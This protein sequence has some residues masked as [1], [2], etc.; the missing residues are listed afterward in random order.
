MP[1]QRSPLASHQ[2]RVPA[3]TGVRAL[4]MQ[5]AAENPRRGIGAFT[6][7]SPG[8]ATR[9]A[10]PPSGRSSPQQAS[11][12]RRSGRS[13]LGPVPLPSPSVACRMVPIMDLG[14]RVGRLDGRERLKDLVG[15]HCPPRNNPAIT[16]LQQDHLPL[17]VQLGFPRDHITHGLV[18]PCRLRLPLAWRSVPPQPHPDAD[19]GRQVRLSHRAAR[20][21]CAVN[22]GDRLVTHEAIQLVIPP[23]HKQP[24]NDRAGPCPLP[25]RSGVRS[26]LSIGRGLLRSSTATT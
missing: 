26:H 7:G 24:E 13:D 1:N 14:R 8:S 17:A 18:I 9:S 12:N 23:A 5:L 10:P 22:L 2:T 6:A 11:T 21:V 25:E 15:V 20:R 4:T 16:W 3:P 19:T